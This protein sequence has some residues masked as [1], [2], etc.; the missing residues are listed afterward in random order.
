[1]KTEFSRKALLITM[2][3]LGLGYES[4]VSGKPNIIIMTDILNEP[5][6]TQSMVRFLTHANEFNV[7]GL[8]ASTGMY[9]N[10]DPR[11][12]AILEIITGYETAYE[13]L[14][15]HAPGFPT[16][17]DLRN[18][19]VNGQT[20]LGMGSV[21]SGK[22]TAGSQLIIQQ[23]DAADG[24]VWITGWGGMNTLA[25]ALWNVRETRAPAQVDTFVAKIRTYDIAG[26]D[27]AGPWMCANFPSI[28][29]IRN[30]RAWNG[31]SRTSGEGAINYQK[32]YVSKEWFKTNIQENHGVLGT[33][34]PNATYIFEGDTPSFLYAF[35][36]G[37]GDPENLSW[38]NWGGRFNAKKTKNPFGRTGFPTPPD[39]AM[40]TEAR[41]TFSG[42]SNNEYIAVARWREA[43][44]NEFA[45]RMNWCVA[46]TYGAAN[47][48]PVAVVTGGL[49]RTVTS[50]SIVKLSAEGST[51]PDGDTLT[52]HWW[53]YP[54]PSDYKTPLIIADA[55]SRDCRFIAPNVTSTQTAHIILA[56]SDTGTPPLTRYQR[57]IVTISNKSPTVFAMLCNNS[58]VPPDDPEPSETFLKGINFNGESVTIDGHPFMLLRRT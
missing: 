48:P 49:T 50:G 25:Q 10:T 32:E 57:V 37:L 5:D 15:I 24:P 21:G 11:A 2:L 27:D 13:N 39:F 56:V 38:G 14:R 23:V 44:Q 43:F 54:E 7:L 42:Y 29:Y 22:D 8:I 17:N 36:V 33:Q 34:Y 28:F 35:P 31:I 16:A 30:M 55:T 40:Y 51:D 4:T 47:H 12:D 6:D 18:I 45:A 20:G 3:C 52:Y 26:Q 41:D 19:T 53:H 58:T 9:K 1:M 46:S